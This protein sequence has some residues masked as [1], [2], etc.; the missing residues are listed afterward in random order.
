VVRKIL[1]TGLQ[2]CDGE[3][4]S[5][6]MLEEDKFHLY[7]REALGAK[8]SEIKSIRIPLNDQSIAGWVVINR[9]PVAVNDASQDPRH[10]KEVDK[11]IDFETHNL[12]CVPIMWGEEAIGVL[13]VVN[14]RKGQFN[15]KDLEYLGILANQAAVAL[16]N[17]M[18]IEQFQNFYMEVVEILIDCLESLDPVNKYHAIEVARLTSALAKE[19]RLTGDDYENLCYAGFLHDLGMIKVSQENWKDHPV[20]GAMMLSHIKFFQQIAPLVRH[21]HER[22]DGTGFPDGLSGESIPVGARILA[23][24]EGYIEGRSRKG[25]LTDEEF[26]REF[27]GRFGTAYDPGLKLAFIAVIENLRPGPQA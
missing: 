25:E 15:E 27:L 10:Y 5:I 3:G 24:A 26:T 8:S 11:A 7:F 4:A 19:V 16:H 13:E 14:K 20:L 6:L 2:I 9:A 23:V 22:F 17:S 12:A 21:H 18:L 1:E